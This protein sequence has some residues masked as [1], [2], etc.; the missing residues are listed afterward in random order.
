M[1]DLEEVGRAPPND[2]EDGDD[3]CG[4][5]TD[6]MTRLCRKRAGSI[7]GGTTGTGSDGSMHMTTGDPISGA[8]DDGDE[9]ED[10]D[11]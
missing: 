3:G 8:A 7:R 9:D 4:T 5:V 10:E 6:L 1:A 11:E 2:E